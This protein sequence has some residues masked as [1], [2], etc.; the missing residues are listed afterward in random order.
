VDDAKGKAYRCEMNRRQF[1]ESQ[2]ATCDNWNWCWSFINEAER[3]IIFGAW[4]TNTVGNRSEILSDAWQTNKDGRRNPG[5]NKS[6]EHIRMIRTGGYRL[7]TF[8]MIQ[9]HSPNGKVK[10]KMI[11]PRLSLKTLLKDGNAWYAVDP[12]DG[13]LEPLAEELTEPLDFFEGAKAT[14]TIN[15]FERN[16]KAR[17]ACIAHHGCKCA[18]CGFDFVETYGPLGK[19]FIHVHHLIPIGQIGKQYRVD[20]I[21]HLIPVCPNCHAMIH[22]AKPTMTIREVRSCLRS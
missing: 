22:R 12:E 4:D 20:P 17:T 16:P 8:P 13:V 11:I 9:G 1:V 3:T 6:L 18:A 19:G 10:I 7:M 15:A 2:G 14:V 5:Y 21:N